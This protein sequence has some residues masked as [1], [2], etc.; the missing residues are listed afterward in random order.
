MKRKSKQRALKLT[1]LERA[2]KSAGFLRVAGVDEAGRGPL[3]GPVV[4]AACILPSFFFLPQMDDS[5]ALSQK[6]REEIFKVLTTDPAVVY[7]VASV[8]AFIIDQVNILQATLQAMAAAIGLLQMK[9]D[10]VLVD[11]NKAPQVSIPCQTVIGGD[12]LSQ[13]IMAAAIIAKVTRD[14][15][16]MEYDKQ[17]PEYGFSAHKGYPTKMHR[18]VLQKLG[19][20]P[21]HRQSFIPKQLEKLG[22]RQG[23]SSEFLFGASDHCREARRE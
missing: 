11:G 6:R 1:Q 7:S 23:G 13:T 10:L 16:M 2:A 3:A 22:I 5:K 15:K 8:D 17:W 18:E 19:P 12:T 14:K 20:C 9:P 21:I 4:A